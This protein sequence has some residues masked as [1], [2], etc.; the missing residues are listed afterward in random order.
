MDG[1]TKAI[2][3][4]IFLIGWII[5]F[6]INMGEKDEIASFYLRQTLVLHLVIIL[7]WI[8]GFGNILAVAAFVF[9]VISL[10]S[11]VQNDKKE[12]LWIGKY[13]QEWFKAF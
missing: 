13:F 5:S 4:H 6:V 11:A 12:I 3:A 2:V 7:G 1:K 10:L 9:L 8:P